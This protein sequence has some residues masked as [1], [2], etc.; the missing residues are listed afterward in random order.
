[1]INFIQIL[2][3]SI[4]EFFL[5]FKFVKF[6]KS[7]LVFSGL[8]LIEIAVIG[9]FFSPKNSPTLRAEFDKL[10]PYHD[11]LAEAQKELSSSAEDKHKLTGTLEVFNQRLADLEKAFPNPAV[12]FK[13]L[14][15]RAWFQ[16]SLKKFRAYSQLATRLLNPDTPA[17]T[18]MVQYLNAADKAQKLQVQLV[19]IRIQSLE[20]SFIH[21]TS[22]G[23][24]TWLNMALNNQ[25]H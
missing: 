25:D 2:I 21:S 24:L 18:E 13:D 15:C 19:A 9:Y 7:L 8:L 12:D 20:R 4:V 10:A 6:P 3:L 22:V 11:A 5:V 16:A 17:T 14:S 23:F 1:M